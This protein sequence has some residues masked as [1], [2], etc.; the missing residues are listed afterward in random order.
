MYRQ[1]RY[2]GDEGIAAMTA[3]AG[4]ASHPGYRPT[5]GMVC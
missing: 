3:R 1:C 5:A 2:D 4:R